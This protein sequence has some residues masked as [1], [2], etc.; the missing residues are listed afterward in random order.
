MDRPFGRGINLQMSV[1]RLAPILAAL[2]AAGRPLRE[3]PEEAWCRTGE[4]LR[5]QREILVEDPDG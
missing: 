2:E 3:G 4:C 1:G 5:G